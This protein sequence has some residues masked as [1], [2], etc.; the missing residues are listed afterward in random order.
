M[1]HI[2]NL[3]K[4]SYPH[5]ETIKEIL[6]ISAEHY[7]LR[8]AFLLKDES[9]NL[10]NITYKEFKSDTAKLSFALS[11]T[12]SLKSQKIAICMKNC[13]EWC[14]S[15]MAICSDVGICVPLDK[16]MIT[17][18]LINIFK[19]AQIKAVVA[20]GKTAM[21][22]LEVFEELPDGFIIITTEDIQDSRTV[23]FKTLLS[24]ISEEDIKE[25]NESNL[26]KTDPNKLAVL[27]FT[28]GTT[29]MAKGVMLSNKNICS[30]VTAVIELMEVNCK[31][32][33]LCVLPL[34]HAY[35]SIV[36]L[37]MLYIG[38]CVSFSENLRHVSDD[39]AAYKPT[40]FVTVPLMLEKIHAKIMNKLQ[41]QN[42]IKKSIATSKTSRLLSKFASS[43]FKKHIFSQIHEVFGGNI[44]MIITGAAM[45]NE[46]IAEDYKH[47][48]IPV[49]IGYGLTE[50]SPIAICNSSYDPR[51][52]SIGKPIKTSEAKIFNAGEDNVGEICIKGPMVMLGY[53]KN[54]DETNAVLIDGWLHTGDLGFCDDEGFYHITGRIKNV[55]V[56]KNGK[57]IYPEELEYYLGCEPLISEALVF[58]DSSEDEQVS[59]SIVPDKNAIMKKLKKEALTDDEIHS[60]V[61]EAVRQLN[62][63]LPSY[64]RIKKVHIKT[65][66]LERTSTH[67]IK[68]NSKKN[69]ESESGKSDTL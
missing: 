43:D 61:K 10:F 48:G 40:I 42:G 23:L 27:L 8:N 45:M 17:Q 49:I 28:S 35:Q 39:L 52:N 30:D 24:N 6:N 34:H 25:A 33:T 4:H 50:C 11:N 58:S 18:E 32:S 20:D 21:R 36:F 22:L 67:K 62:D 66:E 19:F 15:Y 47:F 37:M 51:S 2:M 69:K 55:I 5:V 38:G 16:D 53:Y 41:K 13:Y 59:A 57:N 9:G 44:R 1:A 56:T 26:Q 46:S 12:L 64:K 63:K 60:A 3:Q 31:D 54:Q 29:G 14:V 7:A 68:R 65:Q